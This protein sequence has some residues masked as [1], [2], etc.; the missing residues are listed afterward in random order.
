[1]IKIFRLLCKLFNFPCL[2]NNGFDNSIVIEVFLT[3]NRY[4]SIDLL[5]I[6]PLSNFVIFNKE[7]SFNPI[8]KYYVEVECFWVCFTYYEL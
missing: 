2:V 1:M 7:K 6:L 5:P 4:I 3:N 8:Y